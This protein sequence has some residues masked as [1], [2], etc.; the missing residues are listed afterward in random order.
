MPVTDFLIMIN[1]AFQRKFYFEYQGFVMI[2]KI[3][4]VILCIFSSLKGMSIHEAAE[5]NNVECVQAL[6]NSGINVDLIDQQ[7]GET[8]LHV[9]ADFGSIDVIK[10][11]LRNK[12]SL[13]IKDK[14]GHIPLHRSCSQYVDSLLLDSGVDINTQ[15]AKGRTVL[16]NA[17]R[18]SDTSRIKFLLEKGARVNLRTS[19]STLLVK[20]VRTE[21]PVIVKLLLDH[22]ADVTFRSQSGHT[23]LDYA[24]L[25]LASAEVHGSIKDKVKT[26]SIVQMLR[27]KHLFAEK[28]AFAEGFHKRLGAKSVVQQLSTFSMQYILQYIC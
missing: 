14:W 22:G 28:L 20:A 17:I 5:H 12:A 19:R 25:C 9:A 6:L 8:P 26:Q 24:N 4:V 13:Y 11:L 3:L 23:P 27:E 21:N 7:F 16:Q 10:L 18:A 2:K 15:S 1:S